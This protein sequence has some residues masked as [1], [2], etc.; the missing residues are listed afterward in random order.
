MNADKLLSLNKHK[1]YM[2]SL[3]KIYCENKN[4]LLILTVLPHYI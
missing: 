2:R 4:A 3:F 1:C